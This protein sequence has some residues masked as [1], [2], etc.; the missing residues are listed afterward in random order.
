MCRFFIDEESEEPLSEDSITKYQDRLRDLKRVLKY[1][2][3]PAEEP[4]MFSY[5]ADMSLSYVNVSRLL[6]LN[7]NIN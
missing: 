6:C 3:H 1:P 5:L 4:Q 7:T 2:Y